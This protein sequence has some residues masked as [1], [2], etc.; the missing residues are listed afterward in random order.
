ML[1]A[2][3]FGHE[4]MQVAIDAIHELVEEAGKPEWDWQPPAQNDALITAVTAA[5]QEPLKS[6]YQIRS[7]Q[8]RTEAL[9]A[10][11]DNVKAK[12]AEHAAA[13]GE[14]APDSVEVENIL[15][16]LESKIVRGQI[17]SGEP[18]IDGRDTRTVR[19]IE[20]RLGVLP[21]AHGSAL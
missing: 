20:I 21:R 18:R 16:D 14:D 6:A 4:Q 15:F 1:G 19:P 13:K 8:Q 11:Y 7:K 9:R 5:A 2:V 10:V 17:L 3:M 12:L